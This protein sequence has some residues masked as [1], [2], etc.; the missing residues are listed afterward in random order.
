[1]IFLVF[2]GTLPLFADTID[3]KFSQ[4]R[5]AVNETN[6]NEL[7]KLF[8]N[9]IFEAARAPFAFMLRRPR[10]KNMNEIS[11]YIENKITSIGNPDKAK[12]LE[13]YVKHDIKSKGVG[14]P[15]IRQI[16]KEANRN[17]R[18]TE[19]DISEQMEI[20]NDLM[21]RDYTEDKLSAILYIQLF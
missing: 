4:S 13:N 2:A 16:V 21:S 8:Q 17:N 12:W 19:R 10:K 5:A 14:I 1:M 9:G 15:E 3:S 18:L 11:K 6:G 7:S 20:L